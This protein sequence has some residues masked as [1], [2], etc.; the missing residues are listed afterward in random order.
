MPLAD[1]LLGQVG[2]EELDFLRQGAGEVGLLDALGVHQLFLAELQHLPVIQANRQRAYEEQGAQHQP[3]D[4]YAPGAHALPGGLQ[5][6]GHGQFDRHRLATNFKGF[7][8][9]RWTIT[10]GSVADLQLEPWY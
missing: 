6:D 2:F 3:E 1:K 9:G 4:A 10:K 7:S 5:V 8:A